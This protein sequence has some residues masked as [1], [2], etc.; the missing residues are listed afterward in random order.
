MRTR[1]TSVRPATPLAFRRL[2]ARRA[3]RWR[4]WIWTLDSTTGAKRPEV[5][6]TGESSGRSLVVNVAGRSTDSDTVAMPEDR[7]TSV[8]VG[9][10]SSDARAG[11]LSSKGP[12]SGGPSP[13]TREGVVRCPTFPVAM[14][15]AGGSRSAAKMATGPG[16]PVRSTT[17][18]FV[19]SAG[20]CATSIA[21]GATA[22]PGGVPGISPG[23]A[24]GKTPLTSPR[25]AGASRRYSR[26]AFTAAT[27]MA[28]QRWSS[29]T[30]LLHTATS[31]QRH[32]R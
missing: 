32:R 18:D 16:S 24:A 5:A 20:S 22:E 27:S 4:A 28:R 8:G 26:A 30:S 23:V 29:S 1:A 19:G 17:G 14:T 21:P 10:L 9:S 13:G 2:F 6:G 25:N 31:D 7:P 15:G 12:E 11:E 3:A